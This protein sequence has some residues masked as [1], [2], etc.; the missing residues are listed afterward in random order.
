V[1]PQA[2]EELV[3]AIVREKID[4][5]Q[6]DEA[7]LTIREIALVRHSFTHTL[8]NA[9]HSRIVYPKAEKGPPLRDAAGGEAESDRTPAPKA[10]AVRP[11]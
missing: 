9:L 11:A 8:L 10:A 6:A 3:D 2:V 1:T 5:G 4:D 7:P